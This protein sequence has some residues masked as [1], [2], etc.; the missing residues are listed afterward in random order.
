[1]TSALSETELLTALEGCAS[2]PV[3]I[4]GTI[5]PIGVL[6]A[7]EKTEGLLRFASENAEELFGQPLSSLWSTPVRDLLG[8]E[9]WHA[10]QNFDSLGDQAVKR[11]FAGIWSTAEAEHSVYITDSGDFITFE[12]EDAS[13]RPH[14]HADMVR[15]QTF[16]VGQIQQCS[17]QQKLFDLTTRLLRH[18]TGFDRVMIYKFDAHW[19]GQILAESRLR[20]MEPFMGLCFPHWD[21][22]VQARSLMSRIQLRM[23]T[24]IDQIPVRIR[25]QDNSFADLDMTFAQMRGVSSVHMQY[26]KNMGSQATMTL[27]IVLDGELWGM[28]SFHHRTPKVASSEIR[29]ILT[30]SFLPIFCLKLQVLSQEAAMKVGRRLESLRTDIRLRLNDDAEIPEMVSEFGAIICEELGI[31]GLTVATGSQTYS[32]GLTVDQSGLSILSERAR[33]DREAVFVTDS[34]AQDFPDMPL[35]GN[36]LAGA[37]IVE[38]PES[39]SLTLFRKEIRQE[40]S[41][42]GNP[43][44]ETEVVQG[45]LRLRPRGSFATYL[46]AVEGRCKTWTD[47]DKHL[48]TQLWPLLSVAERQTYMRQLSRQQD[49]MIGEL[50]HRVRNILALV[51]SVSQQARKSEGSLESYSQA[52]EARIHALAAAH[53][54]GAGAASKSVSVK[55]IISLESS[56]FCSNDHER[57]TI[58]GSNFDI[59][60]DVAPLFTLIIHELMTN[61]AKYGALS[62]A[63][64]RITIS[65]SVERDGMA[66]DWQESG[67]PMVNESE[68]TKGFGTTLIQQA[69]PF[70]LDGTAELHFAEAGVHARL[71]VPSSNVTQRHGDAADCNIPAAAATRRTADL[72]SNI[73]ILILEDNYVI[74]SGLTATLEELGFPNTEI[75]S[76]AGSALEFLETNRP[77][78]A[79]LDV[80]LGQGK[81][82]EAVALRLTQLGAPAMF[83]TGYGERAPLPHDLS[84]MP[85]LTKPISEAE[86]ESTIS[87][88]IGQ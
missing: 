76:N 72:R 29:Q 58:N 18:V 41:W 9:I 86:L 79:L 24:D 35:P 84:H 52:L 51:K 7:C 44:K 75:F 62:K 60:A 23:I 20:S 46:E 4:P 30:S 78:L 66:L 81:T 26:L 55:K 36:G 67:G 8:A 31:D 47:Q 2:E 27:S 69:V 37:L 32:H 17:S 5:Q 85:V 15:E 16:L 33:K 88:L 13:E 6:I 82:S 53:D 39:R 68:I 74:A 19:N 71:W 12:I 73:L 80:N 64:G 3:H 61:A 38:Q 42:A 57:L 83:I 65:L 54:L 56:P 59:R 28:I 50:N 11:S 70:E 48:A 22:P 34:F 43:E 63:H 77:N 49:I 25:A 21:I 1:M 87:G 14:M 10:A 40:V 45:N